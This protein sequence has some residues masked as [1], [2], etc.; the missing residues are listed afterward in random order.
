MAA[1]DISKSHSLFEGA[2]GRPM[3]PFLGRNASTRDAALFRLRLEEWKRYVR[4]KVTP[5]ALKRAVAELLTGLV[6]TNPVGNP[7]F[8]K[9]PRRGYVGGHSRRNWQITKSPVAPELP[10]ADPKPGAA[11]IAATEGYAAINALPQTTVRV[12]IVNPVPYMERLNRGWSRQAPAGWID[13]ELA[14][15]I[16]KLRRMK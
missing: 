10:G 3:P 15:V 4:R 11:N 7:S 2:I 16:A 9:R 6:R 5:R 14:R 1:Y 13:A 8:W 12:F